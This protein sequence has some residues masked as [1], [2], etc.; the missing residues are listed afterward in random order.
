MASDWLRGAIKKK[1]QLHRDLGVPQGQKIPK[2]REEAAAKGSGKT[3]QRAR[4]ALE[5]RGFDHG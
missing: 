5:M 1:G 3:A 4:L 2:A